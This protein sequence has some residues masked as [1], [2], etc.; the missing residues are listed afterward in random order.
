[1][2]LGIALEQQI[3]LLNIH[4]QVPIIL[5]VLLSGIALLELFFFLHE[6][7]Q[8]TYHAV[9]Y[10]ICLGPDFFFF[11]RKNFLPNENQWKNR[12]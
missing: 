10:L 11:S 7:F 9:Y 2:F 5:Q 4:C 6:N 12:L 1:M 3:N 8:N